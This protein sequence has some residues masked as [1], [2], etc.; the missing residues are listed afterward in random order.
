MNT[1]T[2]ELLDFVAE[3]P[4]PFHTVQASAMRLRLAGF[5]ELS[6]TDSWQIERGGKYFV[7][8]YD[9]T[10]LAFVAGE[11][12][13]QLRMAAAHTDFPCF[14][15]KPQAGMVKEKCGLLNVEKYGG[16]ILRTWLDRPLSLAGKIVVRGEDAFNPEIRLVDFERPLATIPSLA[17]HMDREVNDEGKLNVQTDMLPLAAVFGG[18]ESLEADADA[19]TFFVDWLA[20]ELGTAVEDILSY[21]L[22][23]YPVEHGCTVGL[24]EKMVS[25]PRL[26]NLT[27]VKACLD[28]ICGAAE[29]GTG[30]RLIALF[31]NEEVGS[32]TKQGAASAVLMQVLERLY[33][34][35]GKSQEDLL[36]DIAAG[37]LLSV[38]VAHAVHPNY[39]DKADPAV[40]PVLGAGLT[41]KQACSQS[42][43]GDAEAVAVVRGLCEAQGIKWQ[44]FVNRSDSRG[45]STLGSIASA[46][47]PM[48]TMDI[49]VPILAMHSVRE[50]MAGTDQE[51]LSKLLQV[52]M[53]D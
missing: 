13:G 11:S 8:V 26:D 34:A 18:V 37:F 32:C 23:L 41:L 25:S 29:T 21:E 28:G 27:S 1:E 40:R 22:S 14:R 9:S 7:T 6:L 46:L 36:R 19:K 3:C 17:I 30:I 4:T 33:T 39:A 50:T 48:R 2:E 31:D 12:D 24:H 15:L 45:G 5:R 44:Q 20:E 49:G 16:L 47:V 42:Y 35:L 43:A 53:G 51:A 52:F 38:D 10:L